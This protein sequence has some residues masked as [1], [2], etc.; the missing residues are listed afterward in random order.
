MSPTT[1]SQVTSP[2]KRPGL[3]RRSVSSHAIVST[4]TSPASNATDATEPQKTTAAAGHKTRA[5]VVGGGHRAHG[6]NPSFG[7][8]LNKLQRLHTA[9]NMH[10]FTEGTT[11]IGTGAR[12][13]QLESP[14]T[15]GSHVR[16]EGG[17]TSLGEHKS[18]TST[19]RKNYST[20][21]LHRNTSTV[22]PKK[23]LVT[24]RPQ[25]AKGRPK[26][27]VGFELVGDS[28]S[29]EEWED[30]TQSPESTRRGSAVPS[31]KNSA[32]SSQVLVDPLTFV[33]RSYPQISQSRS[34]PESTISS[35]PKPVEDSDD[36]SANQD[37]AS[38]ASSAEQE[39]ESQHEQRTHETEDIANR[40]LSQSLISKAPPA[41]SSISAM[42]TAT[43]IDTA[44]RNESLTS[45]TN[46]ASSHGGLR[47]HAPS[48]QSSQAQ[49]SLPQAT[50]SSIE[51]G[52]SRFIVNPQAGAHATSRTDSDPNTPS[53]FLPHYHPQAPPTPERSTVKKT[54]VISPQPRPLGDG[55]PS[56]TQQK[57][58]LQ[59]TAA[60]TTSPPDSNGSPAL[61]Q[62]TIDPVF[63]AASHSRNGQY[64]NG[65]GAV[66][67]SA[68]IGTTHDGEAKHTRKAYEKTSLE[69]HVVQRFQS[70]AKNSFIRLQW[71]TNTSGRPN[72]AS[73]S[74]FL[75]K[76]SKSA[77]SLTTGQFLN[78]LPSRRA[79]AIAASSGDNDSSTESAEN[80]NRHRKSKSGRV[81]FQDHDDVVNISDPSSDPAVAVEP[82]NAQAGNS[83]STINTDNKTVT[84]T[85]REGYFATEQEML[86]R[87][88]WESRGEAASPG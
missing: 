78:A 21:A 17:N 18:H 47:G 26:K 80:V 10:L 68:R 11:T 48:A 83:A 20:P 40:L 2:G 37:Q 27:S 35:L 84:G 46:L 86:L 74:S 13:H 50:S 32:E 67:G 87:R 38:S 73:E 25:S 43:A 12:H 72:T 54:K 51:G 62:S 55:P 41:M 39:R 71:L 79:K 61:P 24:D 8:N 81:Y 29:E 3:A 31:S 77:P 15:S 53:S 36:E 42:G 7:K 14:R 75:A 44:R 63:I 1:N 59:R 28:D 88:M 49:S 82:G 60:L 9:Q 33:K 34:L 56:R 65:R 4:R 64:D 19:I 58:W 6:R 85:D 57:L 76:S 69:L 23:A 22:L 45:L 70:P 52:V 5:H 30:S 16:W 66:N